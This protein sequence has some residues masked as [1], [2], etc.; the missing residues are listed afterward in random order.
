MKRFN[1][2]LLTIAIPLM[3]L[4]LIIFVA[5]FPGVKGASSVPRA[6]EAEAA[7]YQALA[8]FYTAQDEAKG[9]RALEAESARY[10]GLAAAFTAE[11]E[12][13]VQRGIEAEAAR[14]TGLA[15]FYTATK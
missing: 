15:G 2:F 6:L 7:R 13:N 8:E 1:L 11:R 4:V 12:T 10:T 14:Y 9:Q 3:A 5:T